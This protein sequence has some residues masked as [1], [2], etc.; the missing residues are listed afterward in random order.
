[1][2]YWA[3]LAVALLATATA[4]WYLHAWWARNRARKARG[5]MLPTPAQVSERW[6]FPPAPK[7]YDREDD[8]PLMASLGHPLIPDP[9]TLG[10]QIV[11][12]HRADLKLLGSEA[13]AANTA[14]DK[15]TEALDQADA[16]SRRIDVPASEY[17]RRKPGK[18]SE[19]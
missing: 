3:A 1:M 15:V 14:I 8:R 12:E 19:R 6:N 7:L 16:W 13:V 18:A 10:A 17:A 5:G 4:G 11:D 2:T 9:P